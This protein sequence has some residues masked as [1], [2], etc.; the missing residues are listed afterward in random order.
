ML[1]TIPLELF[2]AENLSLEFFF[3][4][5]VI[6]EQVDKLRLLPTMK[7]IFLVVVKLINNDTSALSFFCVP[8]RNDLSVQFQSQYCL[9]LIKADPQSSVFRH[10]SV[11]SI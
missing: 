8:L 6:L 4:Q 9:I 11:A 3:Q 2:E 5:N 7:R 1:K 10:C